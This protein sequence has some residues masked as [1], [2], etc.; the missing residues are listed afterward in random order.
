MN[1]PDNQ[2]PEIAVTRLRLQSVIDTMQPAAF[3]AAQAQIN[4]A[5]AQLDASQAQINAGQVQI[6]AGQL[7]L[8]M[9][10]TR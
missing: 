9:D 6:N 10:R 8:M 5:K 4:D 1:S 7:K 3:E 2:N